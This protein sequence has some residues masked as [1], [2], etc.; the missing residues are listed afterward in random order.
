MKE[1]LK[2]RSFFIHA[3][4]LALTVL[5][6]WLWVNS[7]LLLNYNLFLGLSL[8]FLY[9]VTKVLLGRFG[10]QTTL[11]LNT[12]IFT[13][14]LLVIVSSTGGLNS[15]FFFLLYFLLFAVALI[16]DTPATL[17][18]TLTLALYFANSLDSPHT[19][20]QLLSL[21]FF[22]PLAIYFAKQYLKLLEAQK[23]IKVLAKE[24]RK[25]TGAVENEE[26]DSLLWLSLNFKSGLL[27]IIQYT[28]DLLADVGRLHL[29]QKE[30]LQEIHQ[31]AKELLKSGQKLQEKIDKETD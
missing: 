31:T 20:L 24:S 16:F 18:L 29:I 19:A 22:T 25:L 30:K 13:A 11:V 14:T 8:I 28:G 3:F 21:L 27:R 26:T 4:V 15:S 5:L 1:K 9:V 10:P 2:V 6:T 7:P 23:K 17:T 12:V